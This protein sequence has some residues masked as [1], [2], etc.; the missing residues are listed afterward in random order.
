M[1]HSRRHSLFL[2]VAVPLLGFAGW[3]ILHLLDRWGATAFLAL[4]WATGS[5][6]VY[7][8]LGWFLWRRNTGAEGAGITSG[9]SILGVRF[10]FGAGSFVTGIVICAGEERLFA[11]LWTG[12]FLILSVSESFFFVQGVQ[13]L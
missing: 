6:G 10:L 7:A 1:S 2:S 13:E 5:V 3:W 12:I 4:A 11:L 8:I 9:L